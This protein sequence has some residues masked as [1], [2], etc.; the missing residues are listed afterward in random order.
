MR[1]APHSPARA[2][3]T[4]S[5]TRRDHPR[6][7]ARGRHARETCTAPTPPNCGITQVYHTEDNADARAHVKSDQK[8]VSTSCSV[9][10]PACQ[11]STRTDR[12]R[13][14]RRRRER[15]CGPPNAPG[16]CSCCSAPRGETPKHV[17][18]AWFGNSNKM[19][20]RGTFGVA[21]AGIGLGLFG[22]YKTCFYTGRCRNC[23]HTRCSCFE[24]ITLYARAVMACCM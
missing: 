12:C 11:R 7:S 22:V 18:W 2:R 3:G 16:K 20:G 1:A 15:E 5:C 17:V 9:S 21:L 6:T 23:K 14:C 10:L 8:G 19:A 13:P 24:R 4:S